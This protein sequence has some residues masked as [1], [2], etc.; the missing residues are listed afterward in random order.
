MK[1]YKFSGRGKVISYTIVHSGLSENFK[2]QV[3]YIIAIIELKEGPRIT[4][5]LVDL[6]FEDLKIGLEVESIFRKIDEDG[7]SGMIYYGYKFR[8][9]GK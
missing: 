1:D 4:A 5:Q 2:H 6:D 8:P 3:P 9:I 7:R